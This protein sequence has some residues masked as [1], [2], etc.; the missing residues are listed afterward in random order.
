MS[1]KTTP[2]VPKGTQSEKSPTR[3]VRA[4]AASR[5]QQHRKS[6]P[7]TTKPV[8]ASY[9]ASIVL[10]ELSN[11][12]GDYC[13][14][15]EAASLAKAGEV[16]L[17]LCSVEAHNDRRPAPAS[18][19]EYWV[20]AQARASLKKLVDPNIDRWPATIAGWWKTEKRCRLLNRKFQALLNRRDRANKP[21][22]FAVELQRFYS[23]LHYVLGAEPPIE[24][25]CEEAHYGPGST[26]SIR[27][28]ETHYARKLEAEEC[29]PQ[30]VKY[31]ALALMHDKATWAHIGLD[32]TYSH[33]ESAKEG[34]LRV[35]EERLREKTVTTDRLMF[36]HK[37]MEVL[38][39]IGAQP[40]CSGAVQ[41]GVHSV[42]T[43]LLLE[44]TGIDLSDQ[45]WNQ[46]LA[47]LGSRDWLTEDPFCTLDKKDASNL[48][49][50]MLVRLYFPP[51]WAKMLS[52]IRTPSYTAPPEMGG[53]TH[54]YE[55]F[56]GMGNGT[57]FVVETLIFWAATYATSDCSSVEG[58][59]A[60]KE[61]AV[62]GDDVVLRRH[63]ARRYM[64]FANFLGL[65]F[66]MTKT[67]LVGPFRESCGADYFGGVPVRPATLDSET[68]QAE[69]LDLIG[70]HN[71]LADNLE[72]PLEGACRRIRALWKGSV[73][74]V[75]PTDPQGNL[76]FRPM[77]CAHYDVV[78]DREGRASVSPVWQ[79]PRTYILKVTPQYSD[80]GK[81]DHW[82]QI[83]VSLL[84]ARQG[85]ESASSWSLPVRNLTTTRVVT[86]QDLNR[87]DLI[88]MLRNQLSR[89]AVRKGQP[90][91]N[92]YRGM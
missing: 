6:G 77:A 3:G 51:A 36:I 73:Y 15:L 33:L 40:T 16:Y 48:I 31:A 88:T 5:S 26:V 92:D 1:K 20:Q 68:G 64:R 35:M 46:R 87:G 24:D 75:L 44:K 70:F 37:N 61:F 66:N 4:S 41:L 63:H 81:L 21:V 58:Y 90:W 8:K 17:A 86:E 50:R 56:A 89:L 14:Y 49:A 69:M 2:D 27:G 57:T 74:P 19:V 60:Q 62:Y 43:Q 79:R 67:F 59:V 22:P 53:S 78:R 83:A 28:R 18:P 29:V 13:N 23:A 38:R 84:R 9:V 80:L 25:I 39:S 71:T 10:E 72:F 65:K 52:H 82:T 34:Y 85:T 47:A 32:P 91:W 42:V 76:G 11:R 7:F 54:E 45:G 55:M 30:A 12:Y